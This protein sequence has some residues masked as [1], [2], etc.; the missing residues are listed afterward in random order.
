LRGWGHRRLR[1]PMPRSSLAPLVHFYL[2]MSD[3]QPYDGPAGRSGSTSSSSA[4]SQRRCSHPSHRMVKLFMPY[5]EANARPGSVRRVGVVEA[6]HRITVASARPRMLLDR[7]SCV[8]GPP[9][10]RRANRRA[11]APGF[12]NAEEQQHGG[13]SLGVVWLVYREERG[14]I[15]RR[16]RGVHRLRRLGRDAG[17]G[18]I[19]RRWTD[20]WFATREEQ[21]C[22]GDKHAVSRSAANGHSSTSQLQ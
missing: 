20:R 7:L 9:L 14:P 1:L 3:L 21:A 6:H 2:D 19:N 13:H 22:E 12:P 10:R 8:F 11:L 17:E 16:G 15:G 5:A 18:A 4:A